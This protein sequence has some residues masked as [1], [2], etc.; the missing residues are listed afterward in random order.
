MWYR[1]AMLR[2]PLL[3]N[4]ATSLACMGAGDA[5]AQK[6]E[7][8]KFDYK[9]NAIVSFW[10]GFVVAPLFLI[11]FRRLD[12]AF[13]GASVKAVIA[14]VSLNQLIV[15]V[16]LNAAFL[17]YT[18]FAEDLSVTSRDRVF[19]QVEN[20]LRNDLMEIW[21]FSTMWW[22]PINSLNFLFVPPQY[23]VLPT[24]FASFTWNIYLSTTA[25]QTRE[26]QIEN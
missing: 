2:W 5:Y 15:A 23:R 12:A 25:H 11:W 17:E 10:N 21:L 13:P 9:R 18:I 7:N 26:P 4:I 16:P 6:R 3:T 22:G 1:R 14:K 8:I 19:K 20:K 24:I